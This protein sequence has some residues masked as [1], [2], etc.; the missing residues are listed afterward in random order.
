VIIHYH[1]STPLRANQLP[2]SR[3]YSFSRDGEANSASA[4]SAANDHAN[5]MAIVIQ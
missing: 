4:I 3:Y 5:Q 2:C 1:A